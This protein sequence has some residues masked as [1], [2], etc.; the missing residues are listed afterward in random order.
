MRSKK[1]NLNKKKQNKSNKKLNGGSNVRNMV[2]R[3]QDSNIMRAYVDNLANNGNLNTKAVKKYVRKRRSSNLDA[4]RGEFANNT[5]KDRRNRI[6]KE[7]NELEKNT[8]Q[9]KQEEEEEKDKKNRKEEERRQREREERRQIE[10][11]E[12]RQREEEYMRLKEEEERQL[13][14]RHEEEDRHYARTLEQQ[15][16]EMEKEEKREEKRFKQQQQ[17]EQIRQSRVADEEKHVVE[18]HKQRMEQLEIVERAQQARRDDRLRQEESRAQQERA[19]REDQR[20]EQKE[21]NEQWGKTVDRGLAVGQILHGIYDTESNRQYARSG[22]GRAE[23]AAGKLASGLGQATDHTFG[24]A[25]K[26]INRSANTLTEA[27]KSPA[28]TEGLVKGFMGTGGKNL[29]N[30]P[31]QKRNSIKKAG[32]PVRKKT[33]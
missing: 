6:E 23:R 31:N 22:W 15:K 18:E 27:A 3:A 8:K 2:K 17:E 25:G 7:I 4:T 10:Q 29:K 5:L 21:S 1:N 30:S 16:I 24:L 28:L 12:R 26:V 13:R 33:K 20:K 19:I 9:R 32:T 11:E 14:F